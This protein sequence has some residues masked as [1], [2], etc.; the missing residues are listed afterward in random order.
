MKKEMKL[1][2]TENKNIKKRKKKDRKMKE[3]E[4]TVKKKQPKKIK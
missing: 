2:E 3:T 4:Q 1:K